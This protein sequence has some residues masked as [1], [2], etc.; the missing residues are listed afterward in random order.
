MVQS[1]LAV[2][3]A[4]ICRSPL[5]EFVLRGLL[6]GVRVGSAGIDALVG[7][8]VDPGALEA[9]QALGIAV[10][11]HAARQFDDRLG[12]E[13][14]LI[15][16]MERHHRNSIARHWPHFLGKTFLLGQPLGRDSI[17]DPYRGGM[18]QHVNTA[19]LIVQGAERWAAQLHGMRA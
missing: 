7:Q 2:C 17:P 13:A 12:R 16:V 6:P 3:T 19:E 11:P 15:L 14:D 4:N 1:I 8:D 10:Q 18:A 5:A 9:A